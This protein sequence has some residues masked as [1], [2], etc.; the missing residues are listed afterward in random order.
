MFTMMPVSSVKRGSR[1]RTGSAKTSGW[2]MNSRVV[3]A[4]WLCC[5]NETDAVRARRAAPSRRVRDMRRG[6][7]GTS[8]PKRVGFAS[9]GGAG[10][11]I[12]TGTSGDVDGLAG[13]VG[14]LVRGEEMDHLGDVLRGLDASEG[15][16]AQVE[17]A[18]LVD[19]EAT[20]LR[21]PG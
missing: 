4:N 18:D 13:H 21:L 3:P 9:W 8:G 6:F 19:G 16:V 1:R 7:M 5:A 20:Q 10:A 14:R 11:S 15:H 17:G 2:T 12:H